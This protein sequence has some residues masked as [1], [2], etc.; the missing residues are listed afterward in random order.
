M[1]T[2]EEKK[3][4][5]CGKVMFG[6]A[7]KK[8][9]SDGCRSAHNNKNL[10]SASNYIR[11]TNHLLSRNRK[12]LE[13]LN[14]EG[15]KKVHRDQLMKAGFDFN[16]YTNVYETKA[17]DAYKFCYEQG[18]LALSDQFFLLVRRDEED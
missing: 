14:P 3:C 6:R 16:F 9:C 4:I 10:T 8:Y 12:I 18:Y 7:D 1:V 17:G 5:E 11:R 2:E 15:K 13:K